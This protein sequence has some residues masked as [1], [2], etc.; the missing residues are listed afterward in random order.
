MPFIGDMIGHHGG[1]GGGAS[2]AEDMYFANTAARDTFTTA[3]PNRLFQGVTCAVTNGDKYDYYQWDAAD[4]KWLEANLIFQGKKGDPGADGDPGEGFTLLENKKIEVSPKAQIYMHASS[5]F[6]VQ[7]LDEPYYDD[8]FHLEADGGLLWGP[9]QTMGMVL[10]TAKNDLI[11]EI[12]GKRHS[13]ALQDETVMDVKGG[14]GIVIDRTDRAN[15]VVSLKGAIIDPT[16]GFK[17]QPGAK[18]DTQTN[19]FMNFVADSTIE[20]QSEGYI[21]MHPGSYIN[22][23]F[24]NGLHSIV[25]VLTGEIRLGNFIQAELKLRSTNWFLT[26]DTPG[27]SYKYLPDRLVVSPLDSNVFKTEVGSNKYVGVNKVNAGIAPEEIDNLQLVIETRT[28]VPQ[29]ANENDIEAFLDYE[30]HVTKITAGTLAF[31][32]TVCPDKTAANTPLKVYSWGSFNETPPVFEGEP[33]EG[34]T[35]IYVGADGKLTRQKTPYIIGGILEMGWWIDVNLYNAKVIAGDNSPSEGFVLNPG[36]TIEMKVGAN[37]LLDQD[38]QIRGNFLAGNHEIINVNSNIAYIGCPNAGISTQIITDDSKLIAKIKGDRKHLL[39]YEEGVNI[40]NQNI[41]IFKAQDGKTYANLQI[42][43]LVEMESGVDNLQ[44]VKVIDIHDD[45]VNPSK[46]PYKAVTVAQGQVISGVTLCENGTEA[47][48]DVIMMTAGFYVVEMDPDAADSITYPLYVNSDGKLS[49]DPSPHKIGYWFKTGIYLDTN[50]YNDKIENPGGGSNVGG[51]EFVGDDSGNHGHLTYFE[52]DDGSTATASQFTVG[53]ILQIQSDIEDNASDITDL[54]TGFTQLA[55]VVS[56][57]SN[58][59]SLFPQ[60][61]AFNSIDNYEILGLDDSMFQANLNNKSE[62]AII[63]KQG[64]IEGSRD[65]VLSFPVQAAHNFYGFAPSS[66]GGLITAKSQRGNAHVTQT[67]EAE[68]AVPPSQV[69][70][71]EFTFRD[72][73]GDAY[74]ASLNTANTWYDWVKVNSK[75]GQALELLVLQNKDDIED[76]EGRITTNSEDIIVNADAIELVDGRLTKVE[77]GLQLFET[78]LLSDI[79]LTEQD[80]A[81]ADNK[82]R[83]AAEFHNAFYKESGTSYEY[84]RFINKT[85][86]MYDFLPNANGGMLKV[87]SAGHEGKRFT[88]FEFEDS[89]NA[90]FYASMNAENFFHDFTS[91]GTSSQTEQNTQDI[92]DLKSQISG[93]ESRIAYLENLIKGVYNNFNLYSAESHELEVA[94][95]STDGTETKKRILIDGNSPDP[96]DDPNEGVFTVYHGWTHAAPEDLTADDVTVQ[97]EETTHTDHIFGDNYEDKDDPAPGYQY[98]LTARYSH[99]RQQATRGWMFIAFPKG[100]VEPE[101]RYIHYNSFNATWPSKEIQINGRTYIVHQSQEVVSTEYE[102]TLAQ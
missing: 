67:Y 13:I 56:T 59:I 72:N 31:G 32:V 43:T 81:D 18:I 8:V 95:F 47:G 90:T 39:T 83:L 42:V 37:L 78:Y 97:N 27:S 1:G 76:H 48:S 41:D 87:I 62:L 14:E 102:I 16:A 7:S 86:N 23:Y 93:L 38:A 91:G 85:D 2:I 40:D 79:N 64:H 71:I 84:L 52:A 35:H 74:F 55:E 44:I 30:F 89:E 17:L 34:D 96:H 11:A 33:E 45:V 60:K 49:K 15:P 4:K 68:E 26:L 50:L 36:K 12:K 3:N 77:D 69:H 75:A 99:S 101:I 22:G 100:T 66:N 54:E 5:R 51:I 92:V 80:L 58:A 20:M 73:N 88:T 21:N 46:T 63:F 94:M 70:V 6:V 65:W 19:S 28:H 9:T 25:E 57:N 10:R 82:L 53:D 29:S 98:I 61:Y 24:G